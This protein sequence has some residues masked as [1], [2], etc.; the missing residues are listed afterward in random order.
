MIVKITAQTDYTRRGRLARALRV[1]CSGSDPI[2]ERDPKEVERA[3]KIKNVCLNCTKEKCKGGEYC[4]KKER[5]R[6]N[7]ES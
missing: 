2:P 3:N 6:Q 7:A 1:S 5:D 4:F